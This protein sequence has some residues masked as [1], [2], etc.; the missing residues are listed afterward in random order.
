MDYN[1]RRVITQIDG[2]VVAIVELVW[3]PRICTECNEHHYEVT[4]GHGLINLKSWKYYKVDD[5]H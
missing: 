5:R 3:D 4:F 1:S 2:N